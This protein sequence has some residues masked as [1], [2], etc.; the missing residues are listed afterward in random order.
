MHAISSIVP[1]SFLLITYTYT[2]TYNHIFAY[3]NSKKQYQ[4]V[5]APFI[6]NSF[7]MLR[8]SLQF[9]HI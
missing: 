2:Y 9:I 1:S 3:Q 4:M 7:Y 8:E 5:A 6:C